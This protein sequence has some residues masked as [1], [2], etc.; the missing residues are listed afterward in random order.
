MAARIAGSLIAAVTLV[1]AVVHAAPAPTDI[2]ATVD[3]YL[4]A[5]AG[6]GAFSGAVLVARGRQVLVRK[7]YG[8]AD[9][10]RRTPYTPETQ[11]QA[12]SVSKMFTAMAALKLRDQGRLGLDDPIS[13]FVERCP[14]SWKGVTVR[15][16]MRHTS[17]IPDYEARLELGSEKYMA[18]MS[19]PG[20]SRE[21]LEQARK[22]TLEFAPGSKFAYSNTGYILLSHVIERAAGAPFADV[23]RRALLEP[24]GM[25]SSGVLGAGPAPERLAVGYTHGDLGWEKALA[26][27]A[28]TDGHLTRVP[29]LPFTP[30][31][32]DAWLTTTLDD[33]H[34]W[35]LLMD[36]SDLVPAAAAA[37]VFAAGAGSYGLGWFVDQGFGRRRYRHN[38]IVPGYLTDLI[39]FPDDSLTIVLFSNLD[40]ARMSRIARDV[41][42]IVLGQPWDMPVRGTLAA[43]PDAEQSARLEGTYRLAQGDTLRVRNEPDYLTAQV[44]GRFTA[45]L[46]PL[47]AVE[48][49]MPLTDGRVTFAV[50]GAAP[51]ASVNLRYSGEDHI[52]TRIAAP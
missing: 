6:M 26:G 30:P 23:V 33:L 22:D 46:I 25:T 3:R 35:S 44:R 29:A 4:A 18:F 39:K 21:I 16:L 41:S 14:E 38:G 8:Y 43:R 13:K 19:R 17:G 10:A 1:A 34:R 40:R 32:G 36:G 5:R 37:E 27:V 2:A 47:S 28:L 45:G 31:H 12:A 11:H 51:A 52:G 7:G 9:V 48:F 15:H 42:A 50:D 24:A 20:A 49:Y